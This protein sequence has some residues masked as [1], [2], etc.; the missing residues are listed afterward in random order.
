MIGSSVS[1]VCRPLPYARVLPG[2]KLRPEPGKRGKRE[3]RKVY[4]LTHWSMDE[5]ET[6]PKE[7]W[8]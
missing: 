5:A 2:M 8:V 4:G 1:K 3:S 7:P 6:L